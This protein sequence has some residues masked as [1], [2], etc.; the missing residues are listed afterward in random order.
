MLLVTGLGL[1]NL[2]KIKDIDMCEENLRLWSFRNDFFHRCERFWH[3]I[4]PFFF[5]QVLRNL[6]KLLQRLLNIFQRPFGDFVGNN[7]G[8]GLL[9]GEGVDGGSGKG[10]SDGGDELHDDSC[11]L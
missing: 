3:Q 1:L 2:R 4:S 8:L 7:G 6:V 11:N 10:Q 5:N 9:E